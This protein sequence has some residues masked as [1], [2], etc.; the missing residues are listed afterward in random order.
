MKFNGKS[1]RT[2]LT[3]NTLMQI[4]TTNLPAKI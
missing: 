1:A 3:F 2:Q 4:S